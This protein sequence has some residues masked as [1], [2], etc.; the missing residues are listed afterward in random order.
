MFNTIEE[1]LEDLKQ[2]KLVVVVDDEDRENEG[3]LVGIAQ[4]ITHDALNFMANYGRGLICVPLSTNQAQ[5]LN[6]EPMVQNNQD[7]FR[8][9]F[10]TSV[11]AKKGITTGISI[12]ERLK[13]IQALASV[14][15]M[16]TDFTKPGHIFPLIAKDNGVL[17]RG[18]HTEAAVDLAKMAQLGEAGV[19]CE[20]LND[21]GTMAR[22]PDLHRYCQKHNLKIITIKALIKYRKTNELLATV[23]AETLLPT[24]YGEFQ[25]LVYTHPIDKS[26]HI[27]LVK[28]NVEGRDNVLVRVHSECFTGDVLSSLKCD[29]G[30]QLGQA[31]KEITLAEVGVVLYLRQEGRG[32]GLTNKIKAYELQRQGMDTVDANLALGLAADSRDY[33]MASQMLKNL[34][35]TSVEL[36]TN[37]PLKV[38]GLKNYGIKINKRRAIE[39]ASNSTNY[40]YLNTKK[41]RMHHELKL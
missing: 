26:E 9:A 41:M 33:Y 36:M 32:I 25:L 34:G 1:A 21:D 27:A 40:D 7:S 28:G 20:I 8:T 12:A 11:D 2:G 31:L 5:H 35:V 39:I 37:N 3:D 13:T 16:P 4:V 22:Q 14:H 29:C 23:A 38:E 10:T 17:A 6:L 18:G 30:D 19:I 15:S 24:Q